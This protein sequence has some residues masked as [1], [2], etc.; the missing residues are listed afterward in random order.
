LKTEEKLPG[1][2]IVLNDN[3]EVKS[4]NKTRIVKA[5]ASTMPTDTMPNLLKWCWTEWLTARNG[6]IDMCS[7][8]EDDLIAH[9]WTGIKLA[10]KLNSVIIDTLDDTKMLQDTV[11]NIV[12]N[13]HGGAFNSEKIECEQNSD[14]DELF[15]FA[16]KHSI[17]FFDKGSEDF[18]LLSYPPQAADDKELLMY[19]LMDAATTN[20][21]II[22]ERISEYACNDLPGEFRM[23]GVPIGSEQLQKTNWNMYA[24]GKLFVIQEI[25][26][27]TVSCNVGETAEKLS[28]D[29]TGDSMALFS[30]IEN[31]DAINTIRKDVLIVHRTYLDNAKI[32]VEPEIF[33]ERAKKQFGS[34]FI[35]SGGGYPH[36]LTMSCKFIPFS[37][38][39]SCINSRLSKNKLNSLIKS[40][41]R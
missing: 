33:L 24:A 29:I 30:E 14:G 12:Y 36:N 1:R 18:S 31:L 39:E 9:E 10:P 4:G 5:N 8:F 23:N 13:R 26:N 37:T 25:K 28:L 35:T 40:N 19:Q 16:T 7:F 21:F 2:I 6:A 3:Q 22:D 15:N 34:V 38:L 20:V 11:V 27:G 32:G 41:I 17:I